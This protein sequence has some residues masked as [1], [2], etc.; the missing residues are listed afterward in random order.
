MKN[1][2][3]IFKKEWDRVIKDK[4][5]IIT[6]MILPGL[7]I[8]IIY[9]FIG[10]AMQGMFQDDVY[11]I[12]IC[13][14]TPEFT[15]IYEAYEIAYNTEYEDGE[16]VNPGT[17]EHI[18]VTTILE[19]DIDNYKEQIDNEE[20]DLLIVID[21]DILDFDP[22]TDEEPIIMM[23]SNPN[24]ISSND[25]ASRFSNYINIYGAS[26][27]YNLWGDTSYITFDLDGTA[28]DESNLAGTML[29]SLLPMLIVMFLFSGAMSIGPESIAGE[30]ERGTIATL[31][32]T[33]VKR[34]EIAI[35]KILGLSV[36]TLISACSSFLGIMGSLPKM[37]S[38]GDFNAADIYHFGDYFMILAVLFSTVFVVVGLIAVISAYAKNM[39][40]ASSFIA[41][42]YILTILVS[43]TS[44]FGDGANTNL[45]MYMVPI[46]NTV[47]TLIAILTFE[48]MAPTYLLLTA[49]ANL[50][51][52]AIFVYILN[53]MFNS[54][55]I[56]FS[57]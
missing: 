49:L 47:Q 34:R 20:W 29:S 57:K 2:L 32:V 35:G 1:I 15:E 24:Q 44:M 40:E 22:L 52:L 26:L 55:K 17:L 12:A 30:K 38:F 13:N 42:V 18:T 50:V 54:E 16:V 8:F 31:L 10:T 7:M 27:S 3:T 37:L 25:I 56:M 6:V 45:F 36:L 33:P 43:V 51:Y 41:P 14:P 11:D 4:R 23:Y 39:K 9:S 5:L 46:Y 21:S 28:V 19:A 48:A 53:R